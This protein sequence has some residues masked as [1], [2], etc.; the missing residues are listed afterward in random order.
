[1]RAKKNIIKAALPLFKGAF[2]GD[3]S[4]LS[5]PE[6]GYFFPGGVVDGHHVGSDARLLRRRLARQPEAPA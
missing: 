1:L 2:S 6:S 3:E 5:L 4:E